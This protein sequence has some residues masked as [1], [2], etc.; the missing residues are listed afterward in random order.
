MKTKRLIKFVKQDI[1]LYDAFE[2]EMMDEIIK[3]LG[4]LDD[5]RCRLHG[6]KMCVEGKV[7][8]KKERGKD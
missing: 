5:S 1:D 2:I 6:V 3:R 8:I 7:E 4:E